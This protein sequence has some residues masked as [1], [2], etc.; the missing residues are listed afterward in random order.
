M[1]FKHP[2]KEWD[3]DAFYALSFK[4]CLFLLI[5]L[6]ALCQYYMHQDVQA[7]REHLDPESETGS[8]VVA[9]QSSP[10]TTFVSAPTSGRSH[11]GVR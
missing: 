2:R 10:T 7:I 6:A 1:T 3:L 9:P 11:R 5:F 4:I 8:V